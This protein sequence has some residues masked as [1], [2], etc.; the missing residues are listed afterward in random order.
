MMRMLS[1]LVLIGWPPVAAAHPHIF[2]DTGIKVLVDGQ[3]RLEAVEVTWIYDDFYSMLIMEDRGLDDDYDGALTAAELDALEGFDMNWVEGFA[4]DL[5]LRRDGE[6]LTLGPPEP[7][8]TEVENGRI[9]TRHRRPVAGPADGVV[10]QAY[11][12][13]YYTA[14]ELDGVT[15]T[16]DCR[17]E[18]EPVDRSAALDEV[19]QIIRDMNDDLV[20]VQ[21]PEVGERFA[22][23]IR[24]TC[25]E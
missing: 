11:D 16:G 14:Y 3:G 20:E 13:T 17:A 7:L 6:A 22:D 10:I 9:V 8:A 4:G 21:F 23:T 18:V 19:A 1:L 25:G 5:H 15:A 12:P 2:V 24:L